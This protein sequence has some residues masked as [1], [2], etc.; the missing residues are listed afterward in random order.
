[1]NAKGELIARLLNQGQGTPIFEAQLH[2]PRT[3]A[4]SACR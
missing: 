2:G 3:S 4:P 1:M